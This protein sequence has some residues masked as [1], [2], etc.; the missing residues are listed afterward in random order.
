M[1]VFNRGGVEGLFGI[2]R[3][4]SESVY[5]EVDSAFFEAIPAICGNEDLYGLAVRRRR[6]FVFSSETARD[7]AMYDTT[8]YFAY[9]HGF[10]AY[11]LIA[12]RVFILI[13]GMNESFR[14]I[15]A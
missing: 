9:S 7:G 10:C 12:A 15:N 14:N 2:F 4:C 1:T 8:I 5:V 13:M 11:G 6:R 3:D